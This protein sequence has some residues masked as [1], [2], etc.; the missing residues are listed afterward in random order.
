MVAYG[1]A[2]FSASVFFI[3]LGISLHDFAHHL[4]QLGGIEEIIGLHGGYIG[5]IF[6]A[7]AFIFLLILG[8]TEGCDN[9]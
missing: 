1:P 8:N 9:K 4:W 7:I 2:I 5:Y 3:G 6:M